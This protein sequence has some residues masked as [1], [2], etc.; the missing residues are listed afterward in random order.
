[1]NATYRQQLVRV[2]TTLVIPQ[3]YTLSI[4]GG[5]SAAVY[6]Y[7]YP[8]FFEVWGFV[9]GAVLAFCVLVLFGGQRAHELVPEMPLG[10]RALF[11]VV[12]L[13]SVPL[14]AGACYAIPWPLLGFPVAGMI[15]AGG[16]AALVAG[17]FK[18]AEAS[19]KSPAVVPTSDER[20]EDP[21]PGGVGR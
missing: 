20:S 5:F 1:M 9:A 2:V 19:L 21:P 18:V 8:S 11:N 17:F 6:R 3:G 10:P 15:A 12:A 13:G 7:G 14:A 16:Y 4:A